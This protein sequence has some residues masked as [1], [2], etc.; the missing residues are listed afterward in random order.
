ML[1]KQYGIFGFLMVAV[2]FFYGQSFAAVDGTTGTPLGGVGTGAVK[3][4]AHSGAFYSVETTPCAMKNF[5]TLSGACFQLYT[6]RGTAQVKTPL[7]AMM[8]NGRA[9]DDA[10]FPIDTVNMGVIDNVSVSLLAFSPICSDSVDLMCLPYAFFEFK[11]TNT[12]S[13]KVDAAVAFQIPTGSVPVWVAGKGI[14]STGANALNRAVYA[15]SNADGAVI[16]A[17]SD[18]GFSTTGQCNN[19]PSG[20]Q[21]KV[22]VKISLAAQASG[23]IRFVYAWYN[24]TSS[25]YSVNDPWNNTPVTYTIG[26]DRLYYTNLVSDAGS[27]A[28]IGLT[29]FEKLRT[30]ALQIATRMR[31]SSVPDWIK[32][33]TMNSL[34]NLVTNTI[35]TKD[36]RHCYTEGEWNT[37]GTMDQMWHAREIMS[38]TVPSLAWKELEWWART[39]KTDSAVGQIH[40]DMGAPSEKLWGWETDANHLEYA[41]QPNC[42]PWVDLNIGFIVSVYEAY[43]ATGDKT[44]LDYFWPYVKKAGNRILQQVKTYGNTQYPYTFEKSLNTYDQPTNNLNPFNGGLSSAAYK[45]MTILADVYGETALKTTFQNAFDT[46]KIS[47]QNRYLTNNF[48]EEKRFVESIMAGQWLSFYLKFGQLYSQAAIDFGLSKADANYQGATKGLPF[49]ERTYNEWA[50]YLISHYSGL[51]LQTSHYDIWRSMQHDW[52]ER[53]YLDRN[54]VFNEPLDIPA[55]VTTPKYLATDASAYNQYISIPVVWRNYFTLIGYHRNKPTGE[56][57]LEP[58]IPAEMNHT[59]QNAFYMSPE[60]YGTISCTEFGTNYRSQTITFKPDKPITVSSLYLWDKATDTVEVKINGQN[61]SVTRIGQGY[62]KELKVDFNGTVGA[63]GITIN[64]LYGGDTSSI[65]SRLGKT[66]LHQLTLR[67]TII[68]CLS[69]KVIFPRGSSGK[70]KLITVYSINGALIRKAIVKKESVDLQ[71]DFGIPQGTYI[72]QVGAQ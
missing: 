52:Y 39:Q 30:N 60:G 68:A 26:P 47:F 12:G 6:N 27:A 63:S 21:N 3:F 28:G 57:W 13:S 41:Y 5:Q 31:A 22:A 71:K 48:P 23:T 69:N 33:H 56:L 44:K 37:N 67:S 72:I 46:S 62:S 55:K 32:D 59:M 54:L 45:I 29:Q 20:N 65:S 16:S 18:N 11:L 35:Y 43:I 64:V 14:Q 40:H 34:C 42:N 7:T 53:C 49:T 25:T 19:T 36:G 70:S 50:P 4:C 61:K 2:A 10:I 9:A 24:G 1:M 66:S 58:L 17:G 8:T 51:C 15:T 38:L